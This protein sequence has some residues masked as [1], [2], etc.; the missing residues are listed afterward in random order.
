MHS[1]FTNITNKTTKIATSV[2]HGG[3]LTVVTVSVIETDDSEVTITKGT[4]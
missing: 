4:V 1:L 2:T 3:D